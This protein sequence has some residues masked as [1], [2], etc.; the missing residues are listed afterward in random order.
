MPPVVIYGLVDPRS[1]DIRY[2]G[3]TVKPEQ[4]L[5]MHVYIAVT[6]RRGS[7]KDRW[8]KELDRLGLRPEMVKL[9]TCEH[10]EWQ[11]VEREMIATLRASGRLTNLTAG[12][13][14]IDMPRTPEWRARIGQAHRGKS[15]SGETRQRLRDLNLAKYPTC[16]QGHAWTAENTAVI[17]ATVRQF[18][19]CRT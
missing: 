19:R 7:H 5:Y 13:E 8:I 12:G 17:V 2:V 16:K 15:V 4:R 18:R 3:K 11:R 14:G 1:G 6:G 9:A 10:S